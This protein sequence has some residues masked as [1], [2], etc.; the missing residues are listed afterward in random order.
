MRDDAQASEPREFSVIV[1]FFQREPGI[2]RKAVA[3]ALAQEGVATP[4]VIVVDDGSPVAAADELRDLLMSHAAD[5]TIV[6][7][8]NAGP[9]AA[10]NTGLGL[11]R[12]HSKYI[13]LLDSDDVWSATHLQTAKSALDHGVDFYFCNAV[14]RDGTRLVFETIGF[15][16]IACAPIAADSSCFVYSGNFMEELLRLPPVPTSSV[17]FR[18]SMSPPAFRT[19]LR[20]AGED[21]WF[22][23]ELTERAKGIAFSTRVNVRM[24]RGV[25]IYN[26]VAYGSPEALQTTLYDQMYIRDAK[27]RF[28]LD[29]TC[30]ALCRTRINYSRG[31]FASHMVGGMLSDRWKELAAVAGR[32]F[33]YDPASVL[34]VARVVAQRLAGRLA[35]TPWRKETVLKG[36]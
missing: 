32:Y 34:W 20:T 14:H 30:R 22:W 24:E 19:D 13:A 17:V 2:L 31:Q 11:A 23:F 10:R 3:S 21:Q 16:G 27:R 33:R 15:P 8:K 9:G 28:A 35:R 25:N 26:G 1:P 36:H 29:A 4:R 5:L 6:R 18:A 7:Q 12:P